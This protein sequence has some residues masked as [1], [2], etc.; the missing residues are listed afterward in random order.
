MGP[1]SGAVLAGC[2][3][4]LKWLLWVTGGLSLVTA[5]VVG[6]RGEAVPSP[7]ALT[8]V[9]LAGA[10]AGWLCGWVA[11]AVAGLPRDSGV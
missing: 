8:V 5:A 11:R 3:K 10:V 1:F 4:A 2:L 9:A 6:L 7:V